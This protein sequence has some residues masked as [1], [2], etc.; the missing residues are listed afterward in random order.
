MKHSFGPIVLA[1]IALLMFLSTALYIVDETEQAVVTQFGR[2]IKTVTEPGLHVKIPFIQ[3]VTFFDDRVLGY[4]AA[5][6]EVIS[7][8]KKA[9]LMDNYAKWRIKNAQ[10]FYESLRDEIR[11]QFRIDDIIYSELRAELGVRNFDAI[12]SEER[13]EIMDKVT[14]NSDRQASR[15]G[16]E[17][18][19]VRIK[20]AD[21]PPEN[22]KSIFGRMQTE[23]EREARQYRSEGT[24]EAT[25]IRAEADK[26][27]TVILAEAYKK[28]Q[29]IKG[30]GDA[31]AI[32]IYAEAYEQDP[33][34][35]AFTRTLEA[36]KRS[37]KDKATLV[38]SPTSE[39]LKYLNQYNSSPDS[40]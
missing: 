29:Q 31:E 4:D 30:E 35:Y 28:E 12:I 32:R 34:F 14:K 10:Q 38:L 23:R 25:K 20:R 1:V 7:K 26:E 21:L 18:V 11:A 5:P 27:R 15:Y 13:S 37:L 22:E 16:I 3:Q 8:D 19:D 33:E 17:I 9:I 39:F 2:F 24:K 6:K 40:R 36:Y